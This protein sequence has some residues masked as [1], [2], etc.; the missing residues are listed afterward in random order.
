MNAWAA[1]RAAC[2]A[3][4]RSVLC[5]FYGGFAL[6][7]GLV[8]AALPKLDLTA[9][10]TVLALPT[11]FVWAGWFVR[12][13]L[14]QREMRLALLPGG[15][16]AVASAL[17]LAVAATVALP[18]AL[19][20]TRGM[21]WW[22]ALSA[23]AI[24]A[25]GGALVPLLPR[26]I[27]P[28]IALLPMGFD[29]VGAGRVA[30]ARSEAILPAAAAM[31]LLA[32][33]WRWRAV[34][35]GG[36]GRLGEWSQPYVL[37]VG[38][39]GS[40]WRTSAW[41]DPSAQLAARPRWMRAKPPLAG[42]G[43]ANPVPAMRTWLGG[44]FSL[45][46]GR[47]VAAQAAT[48]LFI[49]AIGWRW[50]ATSR[51]AADAGGMMLASAIIVGGVTL[52]LAPALRLQAF[53]RA[54]SGEMAELAL[55]PGWGAAPAARRLL[56]AAV[57]RPMARTLAATVLVTIGAA[58]WLHEDALRFA[59]VIVALCAVAATAAAACLR[60]LAGQSLG[61]TGRWLAGLVGVLLLILTTTAMGGRVMPAWLAT[62]MA[63]WSALA[64]WSVIASRAAWSRW[65][66]D[67]HPF[68]AAVPASP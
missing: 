60:A 51:R 19:V 26:G 15:D 30:I 28:V 40:L 8:S 55:L 49:A 29:A 58:A 67:P 66:A 1:L 47:M 34:L 27:I 13:L 64:L 6:L 31:L 5:W 48:W 2:P 52:A 25:G 39:R 45:L 42:V 36:T 9:V 57:A 22:Q 38:E 53:K 37:A 20:A 59:I 62:T 44:P 33:A 63:A 54:A 23:M 43:P 7:A 50:I 56:L 11:I 4:E 21:P 12:L 68:V 10:M 35:R 14:L 24:L 32:C 3:R 17:A 46:S 18:A 16:A 65:H 41:S 61:V